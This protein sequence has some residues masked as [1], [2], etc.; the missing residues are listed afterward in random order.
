VE[1]DPVREYGGELAAVTVTR[2][3]LPDPAPVLGSLAAAASRPVRAVVADFHANVGAGFGS[4]TPG[5][6]RSPVPVRDDLEVVRLTEDVGRAAALNRAVAALPASVGWVAVSEPGVRWR[7]GALDVLLATAGRHPRA[8]LLGPRLW[9]PGRTVLPS[10]GPLPGLFAAAR[11]HALAH[12]PG[13]GVTGWLSS[14]A[15][16]LR[17]A[18]WDSVDGFDPRYLTG[19]GG[20]GDIDLGDRLA[21]AGWLVVH[22]PTACADLVVVT[23][24]G[25]S[26]V[27]DAEGGDTPGIG[28]GILVPHTAGLRRYVHDRSR[29]PARVLLA[30]AATLRRR[31]Q[32]ERDP[33]LEVAK[34]SWRTTRA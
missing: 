21:R 30:L 34:R 27:D 8:G 19:A 25:N 33:E 10:G 23:G 13:A 12:V 18:A 11:G 29:A 6:A 31:G 26:A 1:A 14:T 7:P 32:A 24:T 9:S 3:G 15:V 28:H 16:L 22:E 2:A 5:A 17:R 4:G 20:A